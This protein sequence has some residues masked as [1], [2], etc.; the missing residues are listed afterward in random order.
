MKYLI[1]DASND[2]SINTIK[3]WSIDYPLKLFITKKYRDFASLKKGVLNCSG[4]L[5]F[6]IDHDD[7]GLIIM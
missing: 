1:N 2:Q 6:R 7:N 5:I 3:K 4:D